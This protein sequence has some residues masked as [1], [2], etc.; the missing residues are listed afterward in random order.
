MENNKKALNLYFIILA[1]SAVA[2]AFSDQIFS[3]YFKDTY[4]VSAFQRGIIEFP[5]ELPGVML[6]AV[7]A[8]LSFIGDIRISTIAQ[9]LSAIGLMVLGLFT[10]SFEIM[11]LF[12]FI[13]SLGMHLFMP[14]Q[15]SIGMSL[16]KGEDIGKRMG[17]YKA[18]GTAFST[19]GGI[20]VFAGFHYGWFSLTSPVKY[21]F[22]IGAG[23]F[24]IISILFLKMQNLIKTPI[25]S[26]RS[27]KIVF[28]KE[29]KY[30]YI[31]AVMNGAQKQIV[32]VYAPWLLIDML[33]KKVDTIVILT[34]VGSFLGI[35]SLQAIGKCLDKFGI[36]KMLYADA[37]SFILV[38]V[39]YGLMAMGFVSGRFSLY[40][41][42]ILITFGIFILDKISMQFSMVRTIYLRSISVNTSE[43]AQTLSLGISMDHIVSIVC[44][45]LGGIVWGTIGPQ[46]IFFFAAAL[47]L[48]NLV[49][50]ILVK[51]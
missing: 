25:H 50:A 33:G 20:I 29:Y 27:L 2:L 40:G 49:V 43:I 22:V 45:F 32:L 3:N 15:D 10:P 11:L 6:L 1:L 4:N 41:L 35:F 9:I 16:V 34:L 19:I 44:A 30:Y 37:L 24:L 21:V 51:I 17:Q 36:K 18:V 13:N 47:S 7:V 8:S 48:V 38:Y 14:L 26:D 46:Y 28:R 5:R 42:P 23:I 39:A 31:L 12:L